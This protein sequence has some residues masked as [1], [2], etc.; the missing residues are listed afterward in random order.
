MS[1][2]VRIFP[3]AYLRKLGIDLFT[4]CG[5]P[6]EEAAIAADVLVDASLMGLESHG[7]VRVAQYV[8]D[9][10]EGKVKP[11]APVTIVKE[12]PT[13]AVVDCGF[14][15]GPV[16]AK[17]MVDI[18]CNKSE[19]NKIAAV[20][21]RNSHHVGRLGAYVQMIAERNL[22]GLAMAN[23][24]KHGHWVVPWGGAEGRLATNPIAYGVPSCGRPLIMDMSTSMISEG[25]IR[26]L[27]DAGKSVPPHCIQDADGNP[28][29][30]PR[31]FYGPP[32]G[33][34]KPFGAELGYKGFGLGLLVEILGGVMAGEATNQDLPYVN[35]LCLIALDPD[36]FCG[37]ERF[38]N[39]IED[40]T[41]YVTSSRPAPGYDRVVMP[42]ELDFRTY[43]QRIASGIPV[44]DET[45]Q[46]LLRAAGR[47]KVRIEEPP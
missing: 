9:A 5:S 44:A 29:T 19:Q 40:L 26:V 7:V 35:G 17:R 4:A 13:T 21:S 18:V 6:A 11:G 15:F 32:H 8:N 25:K 36:A 2:T 22:F 41:A 39:L 12:S 1:D 45:W 34:I 37:R 38:K 20:V 47:L 23:S 16:S 31:A 24:S 10:L 46:K 30:D 43:D 28:A 3:H 42:G 14:N 33:T 27:K